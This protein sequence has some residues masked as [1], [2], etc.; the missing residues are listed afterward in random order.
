MEAVARGTFTV[1]LEPSIEPELEHGVALGRLSLHKVFEGDLVGTGCGTMLSA[2][3]SV[4]GSGG[5][6]AIERVRGSLGGRSGSFVFQH[7]GTRDRGEQSLSITVVPDSG[8]EG[9]TGIAGTF[10]LRIE[11]GQHFYRFDYSLPE[12]EAP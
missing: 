7:S 11:G 5:Y 8:T 2:L 6:V 3:A 1:K 9:L 4:A 12:G 10:H